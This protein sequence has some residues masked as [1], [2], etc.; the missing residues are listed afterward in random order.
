MAPC[1]RGAPAFIAAATITGEGI[2]SNLSPMGTERVYLPRSLHVA[3]PATAGAGVNAG[4]LFS[5]GVLRGERI[6]RR[7]RL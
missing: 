6:K 3:R 2:S 4:G 7:L 1:P 5:E